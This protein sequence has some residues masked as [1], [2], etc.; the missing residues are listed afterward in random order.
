M[1]EQ[2]S[3]VALRLFIRHS[4]TREGG[5]GILGSVSLIEDVVESGPEG[6][7]FY[8]PRIYFLKGNEL[9]EQNLWQH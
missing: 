6:P 9:C 7:F 1:E 3:L 5:F 4:L 2:N 8:Y